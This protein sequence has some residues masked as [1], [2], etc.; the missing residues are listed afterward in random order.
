MK[1]S[2]AMVSRAGRSPLLL[3]ALALACTSGCGFF[4]NLTGSMGGGG[5]GGA[6]AMD[7]EKY[8]VESID[9]S[10]AAND[11]KLCP[12][13]SVSFVVTAQAAK[14]KSPGKLM[15]LETAPPNAKASEARG[16]MDLTDFAMEGRGG[17]VER[18]TFTANGDQWQT[19][20]GFDVRAKY[21]NDTTKVVEKHFDPVYSCIRGS[22]TAGATGAEGEGGYGADQNGGAGA[23]GG[24]GGAGGPGPRVVAYATIVRT[25]KY[26]RVGLVRVTGDVEQLTLFDLESGMTVSARGGDGGYGGRGGD[27]GAGADPQGAGGPG[28][29]GGQGGPGG[30][31]GEAVV[32]VDHR[33]PELAQIVGIDVNGGAP[34]NGGDGGFGGVGGAAPEKACD[35]CEEPQPG[36]DGPG[37]VGGPQGTVAGQPGR[38]EMRADNVSTLFA[39]LPPGIRLLDDPHPQPVAPPPAAPTGKKRRR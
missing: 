1:R 7:M 39:E 16:K 33:Y 28:G 30:P 11:G 31:G 38:S 24:P 36:P 32:V 17:T 37:G 2:S 27:G 14:K 4:A 13:G 3:T 5:D 26:D 15:T 20:L 23:G 6:F 35:D 10:F 18:G 34:G 19:L 21:R 9:L 12:G 29:P 22:G 8:D 25:P